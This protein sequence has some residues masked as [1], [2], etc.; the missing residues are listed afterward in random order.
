ME[1]GVRSGKNF[2]C[3]VWIALQN[4]FW[5]GLRIALQTNWSAKYTENTTILQPKSFSVTSFFN[6]KAEEKQ[7]AIPGFVE[8]GIYKLQDNPL[9]GSS[10]NGSIRILIQFF[11]RP[12]LQRPA[13]MLVCG[14]EIFIPALAELFCLVLPG[15]CF[16]RSAK[17]KSHLCTTVIEEFEDVKPI[18]GVI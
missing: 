9:Y 18:R 7:E 4:I 5:I 6:V 2:E 16:A 13:K 3:G 1:C 15:S 17:I 14:C 8:N 11:A 12:I 10:D